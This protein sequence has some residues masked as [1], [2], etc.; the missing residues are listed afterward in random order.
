MGRAPPKEGQEVMDLTSSGD[1]SDHPPAKRAR[2]S[3]GSPTV[4]GAPKKARVEFHTPMGS[5]DL[6]TPSRSPVRE[7]GTPGV[8]TVGEKVEG[9][10]TEPRGSLPTPE[11]GHRTQMIDKGKGKEV[12]GLAAVLKSPINL[13]NSD[14]DSDTPNYT[15][16]SPSHRAKHGGRSMTKSKGNHKRKETPTQNPQDLTS[17][18]LEILR[19]EGHVLKESTRMMIEHEVGLAM[20]IKDASVKG[21]IDVKD[22]KIKGSERTMARMM[23]RLDELG[24]T[25]ALLTEGAGVDEVVD[26]SD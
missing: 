10:R 17:A 4:A 26:L 5:L 23:G 22:A 12:L 6:S 3:S 8:R 2:F 24:D 15:P 14:S 19:A 1:D 16:P 20:D 13:D 11:T 18:I 25:L 7:L 21:E 9:W